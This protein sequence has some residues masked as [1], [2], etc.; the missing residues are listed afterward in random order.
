MYIYIYTYIYIYVAPLEIHIFLYDQ[1]P[2]TA[3]VSFPVCRKRARRLRL[4]CSR[5]SMKLGYQWR[6]WHG[7]LTGSYF[8]E[9]C[10]PANGY[11]WI[12]KLTEA[13]CWHMFTHLRYPLVISHSYFSNDHEDVPGKNG[14]SFH[15]YGKLPE[16]NPTFPCL[17]ASWKKIRVFRL[18]V[19]NWGLTLCHRNHSSHSIPSS[20]SIC[21][22]MNICA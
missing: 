16:G 19:M 7:Y 14:G 5:L 6:L 11:G 4:H 1:L 8:H 21:F 20:V 15:S 2:Y 3:G 18:E 13:Q 10:G 17:K 9:S 12:S 22:Y